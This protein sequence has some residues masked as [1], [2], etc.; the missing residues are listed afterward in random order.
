MQE[1]VCTSEVLRGKCSEAMSSWPR[2][3]R[4]N[5]TACAVLALASVMPHQSTAQISPQA[6]TARTQVRRALS[7]EVRAMHARAKRPVAVAPTT[8]LELAATATAAQQ[9]RPQP[10]SIPTRDLVLAQSVPARGAICS[11]RPRR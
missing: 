2:A 3:K 8:S 5:I 1:G 11:Q 9:Q 4:H 6:P 7:P 10:L